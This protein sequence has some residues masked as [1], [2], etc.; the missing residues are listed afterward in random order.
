LLPAVEAVKRAGRQQV[1]VVGTG[2]P[3]GLR[4]AI[5]SGLI[6]SV[7]GWNPSDL[8]YLAVHVGAAHA[9][10]T[11]SPGDASFAA[12]RLGRV[13]V[14]DDQVRLGRLHVFSRAN[15]DRIPD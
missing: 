5:E 8:G 11:L 4:G 14:R 12:G 6:E 2:A 3:N 13:F 1:K 9:A 15:L 10:G 7:V